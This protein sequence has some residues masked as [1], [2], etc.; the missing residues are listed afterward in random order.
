[1]REPFYFLLDLQ[2][3]SRLTAVVKGIITNMPCACSGHTGLDRGVGVFAALD[4]V[5]EVACVSDGAVLKAFFFQHRVAVALHAFMPDGHAA[6]VD[7]QCCLGTAELEAAVV[8]RRRHHA[9]VDDVEVRV[10][11]GS[12]DCVGALPL[13]VDEL[14]T[15]HEGGRRLV[16]FHGPVHDI[17]PVGKQVGHGAAAEVPEPAPAEELLKRKR[18]LWRAT[19]PSLP[20]QLRLI[21]RL[22][23]PAE[24]IVLPPIG[25]H[26]W[27]LAQRTTLY[28]VDGVA[29]VLP[30]A[31]LHAAL[32]NLVAR[33]Y[34]AG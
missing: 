32:Q 3:P 23:H 22:G 6:A 5:E 34:R 15:E 20:V 21:D 31:L 1:M 25:A 24:A 29:E 33:A 12:L 16:G 4:A 30:T 13:L 28:K 9:L 8:D 27:Y 7:L 14:V 2:W 11:E 19:H 17:D 26:L 10:A 18:L